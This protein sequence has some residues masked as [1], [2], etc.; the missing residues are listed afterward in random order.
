[1]GFLG[2]SKVFSVPK[3]TLEL[4]VKRGTPI[5]E[6]RMLKMGLKPILSSKTEED[7]VKYRLEMDR[8]YYGLR[9]TD[10]RRPAYQLAIRNNLSMPIQREMVMQVKYGFEIFQASSQS[11]FEKTTRNFKK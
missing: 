6:Q 3:P 9:V 10:I 11:I 4:Y 8:R 1:M 2:A 7:L 5:E